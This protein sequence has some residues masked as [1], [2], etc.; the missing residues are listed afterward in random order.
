MTAAMIANTDAANSEKNTPVQPKNAPIIPSRC[1]SPMPIA[2]RGIT[3]LVAIP[4]S[5]LSLASGTTVPSGIWISNSRM[6]NSPPPDGSPS[7]LIS[8]VTT[9]SRSD[10]REKISHHG[11]SSPSITKHIGSWSFSGSLSDHATGFSNFNAFFPNASFPSSTTNHSPINPAIQPSVP[12]F[13]P[14]NQFPASPASTGNCGHT[15]QAPR[16]IA[17]P[18]HVSEL[19]MIRCSA[20]I[21]VIETNNAISTH[22]KMITP[23]D[24]HANNHHISVN[25]TAVRSSTPK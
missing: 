16:P 25:K 11:I 9:A 22:R 1:T 20:S 24:C 19:G 17:E 23:T 8:V 2:S 4:S 5:D 18:A 15:A 12:C 13:K 3:V 7:T 6:N 14:S 10:L 21:N